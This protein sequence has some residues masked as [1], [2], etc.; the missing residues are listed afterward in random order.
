M[1]AQVSL[2]DLRRYAVAR[3][4]FPPTTLVR[5]IQKL[6]FV[7]ADPIRAPARAQDLTLRHRVKGYRAGDLER[8]YA[9]LPIEEDFF[10]NYGF[11]PREVHELMHP[12]GSAAT[13]AAASKKKVQALLDFIREHGEVHPRDVD[14]HFDH[15]TVTNYWGGSSS[16]TTHL[17]DG[18]HYRG[19]VRIVRRENG[20]RIYAAREQAEIKLTAP[21]RHRQVDALVD[22][23]VNKYAPLPSTSFTTTVSRLR[24]GIP[25]WRPELTAAIKRARERLSCVKID[26]ITWYWPAGENPKR[27]EV[28]DEVRLL[29]PFDPIVWDRKRFELLWGWA[30]RFEA[31]TPVKKRKLGYYALPLLWRARVIGWANLSISAQKL[32]ADCGFVTPTPSGSGFSSAMDDERRRMY[33]FLGLKEPPAS[34]S[35]HPVG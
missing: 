35:W 24:F 19:L 33:E 15:G 25:Q 11:V 30:Y 28:S 31:Y 18:M 4:L 26:G 7:Q 8:K 10:I 5:A 6:G 22:V 9:S 3:S 29:A 23:L 2:D 21:E 32:D 12:R 1:A 13:W 16:A 17:L 14:A 27:F 34:R 20:I